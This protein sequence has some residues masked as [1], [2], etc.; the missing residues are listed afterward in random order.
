MNVTLTVKKR[1]DL[2]NGERV[3]E[4]EDKIFELD[5]SLCAQMRWEQKFPEQAKNEE[6]VLY[7]E[8]VQNNNIYLS[9]KQVSLVALTSRLKAIYCFFDTELSFKDFIKML[10]MPT[11]ESSEKLVS[12]IQTVFETIN[13]SAS[14][15]N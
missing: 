13:E 15:K 7:L 8:R 2:I 1:D 11:K 12:Q 9:E 10:N 4:F 6:L 14:E 3:I 5:T